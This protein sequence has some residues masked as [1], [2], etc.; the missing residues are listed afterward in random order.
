MVGKCNTEKC[1]G[2]KLCEMI[3]PSKAISFVESKEGYWYPVVDESKCIECGMC[4]LKCPIEKDVTTNKDDIWSTESKKSYA[5]WSKDDTVRRE[6]T[7]GGVFYEI[8][9]WFLDNGGYISGSVYTDDFKG[10]YHIVSNKYGDLERIKGSKYFQSDVQEVYAQIK[11]LLEDGEKVL[12]TG[13]PCQVEALKI[14]VGDE[15]D[16][17]YTI[18]F[19]C[20]GV[21]TPKLQKAKIE[22]YEKESKLR[23]IDYRDKSKYWGWTTFGE[24]I[25]YENG[26]SKFI[27]HWDD[28]INNCFIEKNYNL[29]ESCY[30]CRI[31]NGNN[32]SDITIGDFWGVSGVTAR[33]EKF[34]VSAVISNS[35][36]GNYIISA[37]QEK[38][39]FG[40]RALSEIVAKNPVYIESVNRPKDRE[41]FWEDMDRYGLK[42]TIAI[43]SNRGVKDFLRRK[44]RL[45]VVKYKKYY[46]VLR[47][48][49]RINWFQFIYYN[50]FSKKVFREKGS[51][52]FPN[53]GTNIQIGRNAVVKVQGD[54]YLNYYPVYKLGRH[55]TTFRVGNNAVLNIRNGLRIAYENTFS[56]DHECEMDIGY[57][58]TG[59]GANVICSKKMTIGNNVMLGR[60]VSVFDSD[61]HTIY[62]EKDTVINEP[63]EV[64][65]GDNVWIGARSIVLKG[66]K[67]NSGA[68]ISANSMVMGKIEENRCFINK[69]E[70]KSI[71]DNIFWTV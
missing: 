61:Y 34:G 7:S 27:N 51:F 66:T 2:C 70:M 69:R 54:V 52:I 35:E 62:N 55:Q 47:Y 13:T 67:I 22:L 11:I 46:P 71:G 30:N 16:E 57:F 8:A 42:K 44:K 29:R 39:Y 37:L 18:D 6:S 65:I 28:K 15:A 10:A 41:Q 23:V 4:D 59:V 43:Y 40:R 21:P 5:A 64:V 9:K 68:I 60:D 20:R 31:K 33:D 19:I 17:L 26:K 48:G 14:Y 12:F 53:W 45:I 25:T 36:K 49:W 58:F 63:R 1:T 56:V 24:L 32:L 3:C 50:F 38:I